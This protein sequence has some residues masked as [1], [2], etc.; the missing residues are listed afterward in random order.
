[1]KIIYDSLFWKQVREIL[2][3]MIH[4]LISCSTTV[5]SKIFPQQNGQEINLRAVKN[6]TYSH[7][8]EMVEKTCIFLQRFHLIFPRCAH[9]D[10]VSIKP[11]LKVDAF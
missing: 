8:P 9:I 10:C 5:K 2:A 7:R 1:M 3:Y 4:T 6:R 11:L